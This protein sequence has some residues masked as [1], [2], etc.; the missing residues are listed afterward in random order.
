MKKDRQFTESE[1]AKIILE[2]EKLYTINKNK[3]LEEKLK[4]KESE[5]G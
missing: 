4:D 2:K 3:D 1:G 5:L